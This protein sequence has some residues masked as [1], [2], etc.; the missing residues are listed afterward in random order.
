M[1]IRCQINTRG[2]TIGTL[3][4]SNNHI[5]HVPRAQKLSGN[6]ADN[7]AVERSR[8]PSESHHEEADAGTEKMP[9]LTLQLISQI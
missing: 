4:Y 5:S 6:F 3:S 1:I 8:G 9:K 2:Y 7:E